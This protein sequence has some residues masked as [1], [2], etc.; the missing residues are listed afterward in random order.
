MSDDKDQGTDYH[1]H[2]GIVKD[3]ELRPELLGMNAFDP[4]FGEN[5]GPRRGMMAVHLGQS[6]LPKI[7]EQRRIFTGAELEAVGDVFDIRFPVDCIIRAVIRKYPVSGHSN[8]AIRENPVTTI[9]YHDVYCRYNTIGVLHIPKHISLHPDFGYKLK[10]NKAVMDRLVPGEAFE[11]DTVI[12]TSPAALDD[13][14]YGFGV[15]AET[16]FISDSAT[17]EDGIKFSKSLAIKMGLTGY[18]KLIGSWGKKH[19]PLNTHGDS[20]YYK[21]FLDIGEK[22]PESGLA[23]AFR[24]INPRQ[25]IADMTPRALRTVDQTYDRPLWGKPGAKIVDVKVYYDDRLNPS[26][27][28]KGMDRQARK[29][30]DPLVRYYEQIIKTY[31]AIRKERRGDVRISPEFGTLLVEAQMYLPVPT[32]E[33]KL[34][35]MNRLEVLDEWR[36]ELT[37]EWDMLIDNGFKF[38]DLFGGG[39]Y[40]LGQ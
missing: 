13:G 16:I 19:F 4:Y 21:P 7:G 28:P 14:T 39:A 20:N 9:I 17:I 25:G 40:S 1:N 10:V 15:N 2:K 38:T 24:N 26:F 3:R 6:P 22:I 36:V 11:K 37:Y 32:S 5:S 31:D 18:G 23:M 29:Y 12:A 33:R 27:T 8:E 35:R 30:Y 34:T